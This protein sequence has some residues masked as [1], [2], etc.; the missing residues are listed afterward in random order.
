MWTLIRVLVLAAVAIVT[1]FLSACVPAQRHAPLP[2]PASVEAILQTLEALNQPL[3]IAII[4]GAPT[5]IPKG[6]TS[7]SEMRAEIARSNEDIAFLKGITAAHTLEMAK[8]KAREYLSKP[9]AQSADSLEQTLHLLVRQLHD[10]V[11]VPLWKK[12]V[13]TANTEP[14][15]RL[16]RMLEQ[17]INIMREPASAVGG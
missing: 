8:T 12:R 4:V 9:S 13:P 16:T 2:S 3:G 15:E 5:R 14:I 17:Q 6:S 11:E 10:N 1:A 7:I